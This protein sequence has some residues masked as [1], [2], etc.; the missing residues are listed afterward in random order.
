MS[1]AFAEWQPRFAERGLATFPVKAEAKRPAVSNYLK[2]GLRGS[3][4]LAAKFPAA[5]AFGLACQRNGITV[6]DIDDP[7]ER[8]LA[9]A[10]DEF[11]PTPFVVRTGSGNHQAWYRS[12][13]EG[14]HIRPD[15]KRPIDI[16]GGGYVVAPPSIGAKGPYSLLSGSLDDLASLPRMKGLQALIGPDPI[17]QPVA[18]GNR[19]NTLWR[20]CMSHAPKCDGPAA[21]L[22]FAMSIN[23]ARFHPPLS[24][25]EV[26]RTVASAWEKESSGA[27][28]FGRGKRVVFDHADVDGLCFAC[29]DA[30][31][32]LTVLLRH[33]WGSGSFVVANGMAEKMPGGKWRRHRFAAARQFLVDQGRLEEVRPA[34]LHHGPAVYRFKGGQK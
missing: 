23:R 25:D 6:L 11:G 3:R 8:L 16:L 5:T 20:E 10:L 19:N 32:L 24:P 28:W 31:L 2:L 27:N 17:A 26:M 33:H 12:N 1:A 14:R 29:P 15:P 7:S 22:E 9:D 18:S 30:Y 4:A 21:L 13:G 34:S